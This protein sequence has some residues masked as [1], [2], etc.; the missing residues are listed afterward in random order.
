M[1]EESS[2]QTD[3]DT[4]RARAHAGQGASLNGLE[5]KFYS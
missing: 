4:G 2:R 1:W 5:E 3:M